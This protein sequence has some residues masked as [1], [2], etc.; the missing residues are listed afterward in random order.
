MA[1]SV[2]DVDLVIV[3]EGGGGSRGDRDATLLLLLHPVHRGGAVMY[4]TDLVV[5]PGVEQDPLGGGGLARVDV[6]HDPDIADPG[7]VSQHFTCH[8]FIPSCL[9]SGSSPAV[10][11]EGLVRLGHLVGV[12]TALHARPEA[13]AGV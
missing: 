10:V 6:R 8:E 11:R 12:L 3:P 5:D 2:D 13:V 4:L 1:G 9:E 7:E